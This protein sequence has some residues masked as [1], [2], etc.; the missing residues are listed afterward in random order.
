MSFCYF[1]ETKK[2]ER[3]PRSTFRLMQRKSSHHDSRGVR[4]KIWFKK[5]SQPGL[6]KGGER[7]LFRLI[8]GRSHSRGGGRSKRDMFHLIQEQSHRLHLSGFES[9][10]S[11]LFTD[12]I[13]RPRGRKTKKRK[14]RK[15]N[16]F[17]PSLLLYNGQDEAC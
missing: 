10:N 16:S 11:G 4:G 2:T 1:C 14:Y 17:L 7:S 6:Q 5:R 15:R 12:E 3:K 9:V 8:Q 13:E